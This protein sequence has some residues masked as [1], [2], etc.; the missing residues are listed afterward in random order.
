MALSAICFVNTKKAK[1][2]IDLGYFPMFA[3]QLV[4]DDLKFKIWQVC[5]SHFGVK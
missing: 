5:F 2:F 1:P 4:D 3:V